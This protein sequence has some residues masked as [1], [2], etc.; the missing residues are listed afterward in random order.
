MYQAEESTSRLFRGYVRHRRLV[1]RLI[2]VERRPERHIADD[3]DQPALVVRE[4]Q[5]AADSLLVGKKLT[6]ESLVDDHN[7]H[8]VGSVETFEVAS[9]PKRDSECLEI[10]RGDI[11]DVRRM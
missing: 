4:V 11:A 10:T 6:Y 1:Q 3:S 7:R 8:G 5:M 9:G 2:T